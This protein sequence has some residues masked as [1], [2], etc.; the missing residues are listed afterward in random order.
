MYSLLHGVDRP[1][2]GKGHT[3]SIGN[4]PAYRLILQ[5][6]LVTGVNVVTQ[7]N[8]PELPGELL[9]FLHAEK[10]F[11]AFGLDGAGRIRPWVGR[12]N[13]NGTS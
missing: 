9:P 6:L 10:D 11:P 13:L 4:L 2:R 1:A 12:S 5:M 3:A 7:I 8:Y